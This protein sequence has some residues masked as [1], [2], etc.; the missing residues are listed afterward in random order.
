[1]QFE[2]SN[3]FHN[4][5]GLLSRHGHF[6]MNTFNAYNFFAFVCILIILSVATLAIAAGH[7]TASSQASLCKKNSDAHMPSLYDGL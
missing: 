5:E 3:T 2:L 1:M 4:V 6:Y 7:A